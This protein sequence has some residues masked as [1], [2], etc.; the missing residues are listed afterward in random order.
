MRIIVGAVGLGYVLG[1]LR[2]YDRLYRWNWKRTTFGPSTAYDW[3]LWGALHPKRVTLAYLGK[4]PPKPEPISLDEIF[5]KRED[6]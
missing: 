2:P 5:F 4:L 1:R 6:E 3:Y